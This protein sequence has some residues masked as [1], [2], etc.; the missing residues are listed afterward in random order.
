MLFRSLL[1]IDLSNY[2][3]ILPDWIIVTECGSAW[4]EIKADRAYSK[5]SNELLDGE[6]KPGEKW[7]QENKSCPICKLEIIEEDNQISSISESSNGGNDTSL[8]TP[9]PTPESSSESLANT[10]LDVSSSV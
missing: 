8:L 10:T 5:K 3:G 1:L 4:I 7:L 2:G 6:L 9:V